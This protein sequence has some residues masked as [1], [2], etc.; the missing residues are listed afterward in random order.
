MTPKF[1][2]GLQ[3]RNKEKLG[4]KVNFTIEGKCFLKN[5]PVA[6][7]SLVMSVRYTSSK[8]CPILAIRIY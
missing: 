2:T 7:P 4:L 1:L 8:I 3:L 5:N 6:L